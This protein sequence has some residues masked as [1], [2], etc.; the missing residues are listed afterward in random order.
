MKPSIFPVVPT[1]VL[2]GSLVDV[3]LNV[4]TLAVGWTGSVPPLPLAGKGEKPA[5][6]VVPSD[7]YAATG[8]PTLA[9]T[10]R[11]TVVVFVPPQVPL[12]VVK[13]YSWMVAD[14]PEMTWSPPASAADCELK[15]HSDQVPSA[16]RSVPE[17]LLISS[18][19]GVAGTARAPKVYGS[20]VER[21]M[22]S[23]FEFPAGLAQVATGLLVLRHHLYVVPESSMNAIN[24]PV[25][26]TGGPLSG[27][28]EDVMEYAS[29]LAVGWMG[30]VPP[31]TW[32]GGVRDVLVVLVPSDQYAA[33]EEGTL[34][35]PLKVIVVAF[36]PPQVP[37][38][39]VKEYV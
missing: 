2:T 37:L 28:E 4:S 19:A 27:S 33:A 13:A 20:L 26:P 39:V 12:V 36:V 38:V 16:E 10:P 11:V 30:R 8:E 24:F 34:T 17:A 9:V 22:S 7:Q 21:Q 35:V 25:A 1:G 31:L 3:T 18:E 23:P 14:V 29:T 32:A 15:W 6:V 5:P